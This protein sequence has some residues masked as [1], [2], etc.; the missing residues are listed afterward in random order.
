LPG[1]LS[2]RFTFDRF[3]PLAGVLEWFPSTWMVRLVA[4]GGPHP[5]LSAGAAALLVAAAF[6]LGAGGGLE[7]FLPSFIETVAPPE[8]HATLPVAYRL[9]R[10]LGGIPGLR[11]LWLTPVA[12]AVT[13]TMLRSARSEDFSRVRGVT[14]VVLGLTMFGLTFI[15]FPAT[16]AASTLLYLVVVACVEAARTGRQ[17]RTPEAAWIFRAAPVRGADLLNAIVA[18]VLLG[19]VTL[20]ALLLV[21]LEFRQRPPALAA[22]LSAGYLLGV[23]GLVPAAVTVDPAVPLSREPTVSSF[24]GI[25]AGVIIGGVSVAVVQVV[26]YLATA[27][28]LYGVVVLAVGDVILALAA[29]GIHAIASA[30]LDGAIAEV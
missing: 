1:A 26:A 27:L 16:L 10:R 15:G 17:S 8:T 11:R 14:S 30:R 22:L 5:T 29:F 2:G 24:W 12:T 13:E 21:V 28:G 20:P 3:A 25:V 7:R 9:L 4:G 6:Y 19:S 23:L 18:T